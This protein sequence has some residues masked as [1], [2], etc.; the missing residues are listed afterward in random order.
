MNLDLACE[1]LACFSASQV[2]LGHHLQGPCLVFVVF[3]L[4]RIDSPNFVALGKSSLA[5][6]ASFRVLDVAWSLAFR[7]LPD[8]LFN[9]IRAVAVVSAARLLLLGLGLRLLV[10]SC[11][12]FVGMSLFSL[13]L[14]SH[15]R[16]C[17]LVGCLHLGT[18]SGRRFHVGILCVEN[19]ALTSGQAVGLDVLCKFSVAY[20]RSL[21]HLSFLHC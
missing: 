21:E 1:F 11:L 14:V 12:D 16:R 18:R 8:F 9:D 20:L 19:L 6:E 13:L 2:G 5:K 10:A 4:D 15:H 7:Q 3:S 17:I